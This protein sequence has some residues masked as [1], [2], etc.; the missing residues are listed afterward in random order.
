MEYLVNNGPV[1]LLSS[2][3]TSF[4]ER[5][6]DRFPNHPPY[7]QKALLLFRGFPHCEDCD[8]KLCNHQQNDE[9]IHKGYFHAPGLRFTVEIAVSR[10]DP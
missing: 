6:N 1:A 4:E 5:E 9:C 2:G 10:V 3:P 8:S 7:L